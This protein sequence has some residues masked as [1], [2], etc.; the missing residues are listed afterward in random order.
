MANRMWY[1]KSIPLAHV[2]QLMILVHVDQQHSLGA[3]QSNDIFLHGIEMYL[4]MEG[5]SKLSDT[6]WYILHL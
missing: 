5:A 4:H 2:F 3:T 6:L 1:T